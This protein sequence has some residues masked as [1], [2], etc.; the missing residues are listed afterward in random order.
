MYEAFAIQDLLQTDA[1]GGTRYVELL[2]A[3]FGV[4]SPDFR[5]QRP[6]YLGG[7]SIP[8]S[9]E[10]VPQ[11]SES[12]TTELGTLAAQGVAIAN[13]QVGFFKSF[14]EHGHILGLVNV[15]ADLTYHQGV[16]R[17]FSQD[18]R[19]DWY[20][21]ALANLAEQPVYNKEIYAVGDGGAS[22]D[23]VFGYQEAW[24]HYRYGISMF[25]SHDPE[26]H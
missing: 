6:E 15:R 18:T 2:N 21:P 19:Y 16:H 24:A 1:R 12:N 5:L 23:N 4:T 13:G 26:V 8:F 17:E 20:F 9:V 22:D 10:I 14:V 11:T 25:P 7:A 3:H